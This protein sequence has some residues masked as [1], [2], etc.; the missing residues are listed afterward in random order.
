M[1]CA[2]G[3]Q[4]QNNVIS[5][6]ANHPKDIPDDKIAKPLTE[7]V[8][9]PVT[10]APSMDINGLTL[11]QSTHSQSGDLNISN[12]WTCRDCGAHLLFTTAYSCDVCPGYQVCNDCF[13][14]GPS[15]H[16]PTHYFHRTEPQAVPSPHFGPIEPPQPAQVSPRFNLDDSPILHSIEFGSSKSLNPLNPE[17]ENSHEIVTTTTR[18]KGMDTEGHKTINLYTVMGVLGQG[19]H[20][21]VKL[22]KH[23]QTKEFHAIK[24]MNR[25]HFARTRGGLNNVRRE[26]AI[27]KRL[28]HPNVIRLHEVIDDPTCNKMYLILEHAERGPVYT[29]TSDATPLAVEDIRKYAADMCCG[30]EYLH[31]HGIVHRDIKPA[32]ILVMADGTAKLADFGVSG[33][34]DELLRGE[35]RLEGSPAFLAPE[36]VPTEYSDETGSDSDTDSD[37]DRQQALNETSTPTSK[38]SVCYKKCDVWSLGVTLYTMTYGRLPFMADSFLSIRRILATQSDPEYTP[39]CPN[40]ELTDMIRGMLCRDPDRRLSLEDVMVHPFIRALCVNRRVSTR[41]SPT[42]LNLS[43]ALIVGAHI[44]LRQVC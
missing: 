31:T 39:A 13:F 26:V 15:N 28:D 32:N 43:G 41:P 1:G 33:N 21:K 12:T 5:L 4:Q 44:R 16:D 22:A 17:S 18:S 11:S 20:A 38:R 8:L 19:T 36:L 25:N 6:I 40:A 2:F 30:L 35:A 24:V 3:K 9:F 27:M 29:L 7:L 37:T 34:I 23:I 14:Q 10:S 42:E